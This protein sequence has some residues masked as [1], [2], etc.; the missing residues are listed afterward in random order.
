MLQKIWTIFL[1]D[2]KVNVRDFLGLYLLVI[3]LL[4]AVGI[5]LLAPSVNDTAARIVLIDGDN[6]E[7]A[8]YLDQFAKV[9][10]LPDVAAATERVAERDE[11][12]AILP[13]GDGYYILAQGNEP[14]SVIDQGKVFK[15]F[16]E[17]DLRVDETT[18]TLRDF[19]RTEPPIK[20]MLVNAAILFTSVLGGMMIAINI[21]EEKADH[22]IS[23]MNLA[24]ISKLTFV[25]G[26]SVMGMFLAIYGSIAILLITGYGSVSLGQM[27]VALVSVTV[28]SVLVGFIQGLSNDDVMNA[29]ASIK[30]LFVPLA[31]GIA[32]AELLGEQWQILFYWIPYYWSYIGNEAIL[33]YTSTWPQTLGY[34]AIV[35]VICGVA[36]LGLASR[37]RKGLA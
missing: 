19:G 28:L 14:E 37:I 30:L 25:L 36:Y 31:A 16:Y 23:A 34:T 35:L 33:S 2:L 1:R 26:K 18:A 3:P 7:M 15:S 21:V 4:F 20:K 5:R 8:T 9:E 11:V 12:L 22:T 10:L 13:E 24:P 29:A 6:P 27:M 17:L 32:G